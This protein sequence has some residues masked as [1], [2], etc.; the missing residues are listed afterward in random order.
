MQANKQILDA[1]L[2]KKKCKLSVTL[3]ESDQS[4]DLFASDM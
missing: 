1:C 3:Q 2:Q 4:A